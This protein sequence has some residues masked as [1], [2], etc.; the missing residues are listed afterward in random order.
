MFP[1]PWYTEDLGTT[2]PSLSNCH[3][4]LSILIA[5]FKFSHY[6][7]KKGRTQAAD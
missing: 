7:L 6:S 3:L 5:D 1:L 4:L 2:F